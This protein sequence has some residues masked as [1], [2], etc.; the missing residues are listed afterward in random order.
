MLVILLNIKYAY[1]IYFIHTL[2]FTAFDQMHS[3]DYVARHVLS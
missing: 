1:H 2:L 3:E